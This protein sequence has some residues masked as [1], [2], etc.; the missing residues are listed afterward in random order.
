MFI[1]FYS[2]FVVAYLRMKRTNRQWCGSGF[3]Q[4]NQQPCNSNEGRFLKLYWLN[5]LDNFKSPSFLFFLFSV[6]PRAPDS[7]RIFLIFESRTT[8]ERMKQKRRPLS[9]L[10]NTRSIEFFKSLRSRY[11]PDPVFLAKAGSTPLWTRQLTTKDE[12]QIK[13]QRD[14]R[15]NILTDKQQSAV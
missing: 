15:T 10:K 3:G 4:K 5:I 2:N 7:V 14:E 6:I 13:R 9:Y 1:L 8:M 11:R 12:R